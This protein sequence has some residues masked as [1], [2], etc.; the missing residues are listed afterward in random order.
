MPVNYDPVIPRLQLEQDDDT[1]TLT[2]KCGVVEFRIALTLRDFMRLLTGREVYPVAKF[3]PAIHVPTGI[4]K[5]SGGCVTLDA[6]TLGMT[7]WVDGQQV[8]IGERV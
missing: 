6:D 7:T 2:L 5:P 8:E 3:T 1:A 4:L